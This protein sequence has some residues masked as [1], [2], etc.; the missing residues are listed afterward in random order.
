M[1]FLESFV[2]QKPRKS[3]DDLMRLK[4]VTL[5]FPVNHIIVLDADTT[6]VSEKFSRSFV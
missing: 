6:F 5:S 1:E 3:L 2:S 4:D